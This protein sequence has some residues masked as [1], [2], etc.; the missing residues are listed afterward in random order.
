MWRRVGALML[1]LHFTDNVHVLVDAYE[2][3]LVARQL[4]VLEGRALGHT[5]KVAPR[6]PLAVAPRARVPRPFLRA[7]E[8][9]DLA[10]A[11]L[12]VTDGANREVHHRGGTAI[13]AGVLTFSSSGT[14]GFAHLLLKSR[15]CIGYN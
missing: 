6:A 5:Q 11:H 2:T 7:L 14:K 13:D 4:P 9:G 3:A 12:M 15:H 8:A 1:D 10:A